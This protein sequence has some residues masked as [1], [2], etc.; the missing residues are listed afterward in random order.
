M[1]EKRLYT[2]NAFCTHFVEAHSEDE[3]IDLVY[4]ALLGNDKNNILGAGEVNL[5]IMIARQG[6]FSNIRR[7]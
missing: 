2:V 5:D 4:E 7:D 1:D 3:A 6:Y